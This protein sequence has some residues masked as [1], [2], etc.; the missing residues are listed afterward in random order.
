MN[1]PFLLIAWLMAATLVT[2]SP[3][4]AYFYTGNG[5]KEWVDAADRFDSGTESTDDYINISVLRGYIAGVYDSWEGS[6]ICPPAG[7]TLG[8]FKDI[9]KNYLQDNPDKWNWP[10]SNLIIMS[11]SAKFP[12]KSQK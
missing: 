6:A 12:C 2:A 11:A 10:A 8:Q 3:V 5:L 7:V 9:L 4:N 1:K